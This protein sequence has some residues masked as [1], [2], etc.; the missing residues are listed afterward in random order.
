MLNIDDD[1]IGFEILDCENAEMYDIF[2]GKL[3][4]MKFFSS[5]YI[6]KNR[7]A[8]DFHADLTLLNTF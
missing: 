2:N 8:P 3:T 5:W 1:G 4:E 6:F 7:V